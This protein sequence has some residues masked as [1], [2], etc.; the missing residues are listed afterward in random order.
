MSPPAPFSLFTAMWWLY[1]PSIS[2]YPGLM[3]CFA[4]TCW[5][6]LSV[7]VAMLTFEVLV[8]GLQSRR[9]RDAKT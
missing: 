7:Q 1:R 5:M 9:L 3:Q 8:A 6:G 2:L 4:W